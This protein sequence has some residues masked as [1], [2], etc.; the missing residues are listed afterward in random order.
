MK[1]NTQKGKE[2]EI[3]AENFLKKKGIKIIEKNYRTKFGEIDLIGFDKRTIIFIE[4]KLRNNNKF[5]YPTE[6][7]TKKKLS[8]LFQSAEI[9]ISQRNLNYN[10]RF[11]VIAIRQD[12]MNRCYHLE[13]FKDQKFD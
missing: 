4:V 8:H 12:D 1:N 9:F 7:I 10:Y 6:A 5:G 2:G 11:D 13:W 3:L